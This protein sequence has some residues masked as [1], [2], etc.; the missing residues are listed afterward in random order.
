MT[1]PNASACLM[2]ARARWNSPERARCVT[3]PEM[4]TTSK[5]PFAIIASIAS[6][7]SGTAG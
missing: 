1:L 5:V 4:A 7:C 2:K 6:Y 3:S